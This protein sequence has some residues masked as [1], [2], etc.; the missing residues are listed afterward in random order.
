MQYPC[1]IRKTYLGE[2]EVTFPDFP[3]FVQ[4]FSTEQQAANALEISLVDAMAKTIASSKQ[5][6]LPSRKT[7]E[8]LLVGIDGQTLI[9]V[10]LH[11]RSIVQ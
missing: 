6:P 8:E 10:Q 11:N 2:F 1:R 4:Y 5:V 3:S 7:A 9:Q